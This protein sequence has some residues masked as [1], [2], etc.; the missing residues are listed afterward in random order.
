MLQSIKRTI[1]R[2]TVDLYGRFTEE[3]NMV[4]REFSGK[5][6]VLPTSFP[7]QAGKAMWARSLKRRIDSSMKVSYMYMYMYY[8]IYIYMHIIV[9]LFIICTCALLVTYI[10]VIL[11]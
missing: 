7:R 8:T 6:P 11:F 5:A 9:Y 2:R 4:K 10:N 1:D 3:L